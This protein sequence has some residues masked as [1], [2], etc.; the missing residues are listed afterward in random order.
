MGG[1]LYSSAT[2]D[3]LRDSY[4]TKATSAIFKSK[5]IN[6]GMDPMNLS[7]RESRDSVANPNSIAIQLWLDV[8]GSMGSIPSFLI[9][10]KLGSLIETLIKH[11]IQ[12]P[13]VLFGGIG[14]HYV[15]KSPLQ[16]GQ[17]ESGTLELDKWLTGLFLEGGGGGT[18]EES[19]LLAW[20]LAARHTSI[21]CLEKRGKKGYLFT[22][23]DENT[24]EI[25]SKDVVKSLMGYN[26]EEDLS[27]K[28][29]LK[30]AMQKY[31]VFHI[32]CAD[33]IPVSAVETQWRDLLGERFIALE[34]SNNLAETVAST[35]AIMEGVDKKSVLSTFDKSIAASVESALINVS[36]NSGITTTSVIEF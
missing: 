14:D 36:G 33:S 16:V 31:E 2:Y 32:H 23:G 13:A 27:A 25:L 26:P 22:V 18:G 12:N 29:L 8:T 11:K 10:N 15:D 17:F 24:H 21:D 1:T 6:S 19:Y 30:E 4:K 9:K 20:L 34:D 35:I 28:Q 3:T 5:S 7:I